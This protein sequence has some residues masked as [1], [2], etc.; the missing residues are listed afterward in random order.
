MFNDTFSSLN[1]SEDNWMQLLFGDGTGDWK[2]ST[3]KHRMMLL[4]SADEISAG[5]LCNA[6]YTYFQIHNFVTNLDKVMGHEL[7][8]VRSNDL[9][10]IGMN[11]L[12]GVTTE[13]QMDAWLYNNR[14]FI[15]SKRINRDENMISIED[16]FA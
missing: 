15:K 4:S 12:L 8:K 1:V 7:N 3:I 6:A 10:E 2:Y 14:T 13:D 11:K 16:F 5:L 9:R